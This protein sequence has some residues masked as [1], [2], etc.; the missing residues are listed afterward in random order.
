M[1]YDKNIDRVC[2]IITIIGLLV[3]VL[4]MNGEKL[5]I[6]K[7][8]DEDSE[9]NSDLTYFT[10][11]DQDGEWESPDA[12]VI[13][14][15]GDSAGISGNGAYAYNGSVVISNAGYYVIS[16]TLNN[17]FISVDAYD[18][19]KVWIKLDGVNITSS[20]NACIRVEEA[21]K[22][23]LTLA[24]GSENFLSSGAEF[25][26]SALADG[27][28]GAIFA[29]DDLTIN[30]S[31]SLTITGEYKHGIDAN[32]DLII[33]GGTINVTAAKDGLHA[34]DSLRIMNTDLTVSAGDD[35]LAV[36]GEGGYLV[37]ESGKVSITS[38]DDAVHTAG[39]ITISGG[40][41]NISA[42]DDGIHSDTGILITDGIVNISK[43]Y[44][45]I[46]AVTI[47][48]AGGDITI[49][50]SDDGINANGGSGGFGMMGGFGRNGRDRSAET[51]VAAEQTE[52]ETDE[53][54]WV[55][56][57]GGSVT[58]VNE[59][60]RDADG[61]DS[62]GDVYIS[63]G[64]I[65]VSLPGGGGNNAIDFGS[66]SGGK[67]LISGG[68]LAAAGG[69]QMLENFDESSEQPVIMYN[70]TETV[71]AGTMVLLQDADGKELLNYAP[72]RSFNSIFLSCP[73]M[74]VGETYTVVIG[75]TEE[76]LTLEADAVTVGSA[77]MGF[78]GGGFDRGGRNKGGGRFS[79]AASADSTSES[80]DMHSIDDTKMPPDG[81]MSGVDGTSMP[82]NGD[83]PS[84]DGTI[85][86][87]PGEMMPP[88][89]Q[90]PEF[91]GIR[92][93]PAGMPDG[94][95]G[96]DGMGGHMGRSLE[97]METEDEDVQAVVSTAKSLS[98]FEPEV[99][100]MLGASVIVLAAALI[101][102]L[103]YRRH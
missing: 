50:P 46:E 28:G 63:G 95:M 33:T 31:G 79:P 8:V 77:G 24:E 98:E 52:S 54:T 94:N 22:V 26:E 41:V 38:E 9:K 62:N 4:F 56:I 2:I 92:T 75:E 87:D 73:E 42:G 103:K 90:M 11:N 81:R 6:R 16:G 14:L 96:R 58:I 59:D 10:A 5:G 15:N 86:P 32:D 12:T 100:R 101:F 70:L 27:T 93:P 43:C 39:D 66:E 72:P 82:E 89:G 48:I 47:D 65:R 23:F 45:G 83:R 78:M 88:D 97:Q 25:S 44:E 29:R 76:K 68:N 1:V 37:I 36:S 40:T 102:A 30:G 53:E 13:T 85:M 64:V 74:K 7:I 18:S 99:R 61:I 91:D 67:A 19:S 51:P 20:D 21:D 84:F 69:A 60:A 55:R 35:G 57:S 3:T 71:E 49:N 80:G 17:G 34:N